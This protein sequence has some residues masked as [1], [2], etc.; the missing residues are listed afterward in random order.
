MF[1]LLAALL[2]A[3]Q[4]QE[5]GPTTYALQGTLMVQVYKDPTTAAQALAHDHVIVASG[6]MGTATWDPTDPSACKVAIT[7]PVAK[8]VVDD[9]A[10]RKRVG[11]TTF[12]DEGQRADIRESMLDEGQLH[13]A[14]F[15]EIRFES[16]KCEAS[17]AATVVTGNM[18]VRG[19]TKPVTLN[20]ALKSDST[21]FVAKGSTAIRATDFGFEPYS[22]L[23]GALKNQDRM[24]L[25]IDVTGAPR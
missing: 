3:A 14:K 22:A 19:V 24:V 10:T 15:P 18:T 23:L 2:S 21:S 1:V 6:W 17:G 25:T 11:Y 4:A 7:V 20:A 13:G 8:L 16:T 12:P 9:E 5:P